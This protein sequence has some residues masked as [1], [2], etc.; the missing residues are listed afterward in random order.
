MRLSILLFFAFVFAAQGETFSQS[1]KLT[2]DLTKAKLIDVLNEI[3]EQTDYHFYFNI[4]LDNYQVNQVKVKDQD[5]R[6][7]LNMMLPELGLGYEIV[8]R[9][10]VIK[11]VDE[12]Q[13]SNFASQQQINV[14]GKVTDSSNSPLPGVTVVLKG[15]T[16]GTITDANGNYSLA[17]VS[18]DATMVFSFVGMRTQEIP[19]AGKTSVG[20]VMEEDAIGIDEVVAVGYGTQK[21]V[22]LTG[23]VATL[24]GDKLAK[25]PAVNVTQS[26]AGH[27]PG[28]IINS[29]SGEPGKDDSEIY[30]R[31]RSTLGNTSAL[32]I[33]DGVERG[34]MGQLNP[35]DIE[36]ISVL[37]DA[38]A[39]IYGARA[40]N[41]VI[42]ITTKRGGNEKPTINL[43]YDMG[44]SQPTRNPFMA[45]SYTFASVYNEIE[46][47]EG[48]TPKYSNEELQKYK[49]G[50]DP[51]YP[52]TDWYDFIVRD[53]TPQYRVN[54]SVSGGN[55][56]TRYYFSFGSVTQQGQYRNSST[57]LQ[58]Y[59]LRSNIDVDITDWF[60]LGMNVSGR[61]DDKNYPIRGANEL[62]SHIYLYQPNWQPYYPGTDYKMP[63]RGNESILNWVSNNAGYQKQD[64][65][66]VQTTLSS[67][68]KI[69]GVE[70]LSVDGSASYDFGNI[71]SK[72]FET[73]S[74]VYYENE[75]TGEYVKSRSG[76][77][78]ELARLTDR[79]EY[80]SLFYL[81]T[82]VNY[83]RTFGQHKVGVMVGY[84][85]TKTKGNYLSA[86][87]SD[88]LTASIPQLFAGSSDK[89]KQS[90][91]GNA[92]HFA[93]QNVFSRFNYDYAGKYLLQFTMRADGSSNFPSDE[94]F[95]YFPSVSAGW[96]ISEESFIKDNLEFLQNLKLRG[97]Y[98]KM[99]NDRVDAFQYLKSYGFGNRYVIGGGDVS[100]LVQ[101]NIPN[102]NITWE[103]AETWNGGFDAT[104]WK[105]LLGIEFDY[106]KTRR[107]D[108]LTKRTAIIPDYTG[109]TLPDENIGIVDNKG[110]ELVLSHNRKIRDFTY[111]ISGNVSFARNKVIF[112]DEQPASEPYQMATGRPYGAPLIYHAIGIFKDETDLEKYPHMLGARPGD[113][114]YEDANGDKVINSRDR[115]RI[116]ET[117][118]P[119]IVFGLNIDMKYKNFDLSL[120][121]QGQENAKQ[122]F[123]GYFPVMSYSLGNF[124]AWRANDRWSPEN[125]EATMPR[126]S[127]GLW[128]NNTEASTQWLV[129][130][131][132]LRL[133]NVELSYSIPSHICRKMML[134]NISVSASASNLFFIYDHMKDLGFD[135]ETN[136]YW[137]YP[138]QRVIN[139][140]VNVTF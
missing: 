43:S 19:V 135:P 27:L 62:N 34:G 42:L 25:S 57:K 31:G 97:S 26:L 77:S 85:Q 98:G 55:E 22:N 46:D 16:Q 126:G 54:A 89:E 125:M 114:I 69:P 76:M 127:S 112:S 120:L 129:D 124:L 91:T 109:L 133:K 30:I 9:Y 80:S 11:K 36:S 130:A 121:F 140:G 41:G 106:F 101:S 82:K 48:R 51:N 52:N 13:K 113:I 117:N 39:A 59:N 44:L 84:E 3:E 110:F 21:K 53:V 119:E 5:I 131:G 93:R 75:S 23:S 111:N 37:K 118:V 104:L 70:G 24:K 123:G 81:I 95:G 10:I 28:V 83:E 96:R 32:I 64:V 94:R 45:D 4:D 78:P 107:S 90:N 7:V 50:S 92:S 72:S 73:P 137:Y 67:K 15:T 86:S 47:I 58:Q 134:Q 56:R 61:Y 8:D 138:Q 88:F 99:G 79:A 12:A 87:R 20:V 6:K 116:N 139:L 63:L 136:N 68:I 33:I 38:S 100:G 108:I 2:L 35:N 18:S 17:N 71:F 40:A 49:D 102:P 65:K 132:F 14:S 74:Y 128:N 60:Q 103:T 66:S 105:G 1:S 122:Y 115:I 29:R